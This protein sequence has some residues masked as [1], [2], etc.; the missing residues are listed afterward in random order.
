MN[1][2]TEKE[3]WTKNRQTA[4]QINRHNGGKKT[5]RQL[6]RQIQMDGKS[7]LDKTEKKQL[8]R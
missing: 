5:V 2:Q 1:G 7:P 8:N 3:S 4:G 6:Y